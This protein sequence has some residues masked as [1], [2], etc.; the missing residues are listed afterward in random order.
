MQAAI[1]AD[2]EELE[3]SESDVLESRKKVR[4]YLRE[5]VLKSRPEPQLRNRSVLDQFADEDAKSSED[6]MDYQRKLNTKGIENTDSDEESLDNRIIDRRSKGSRNAANFQIEDDSESFPAVGFEKVNPCIQSSGDRVS[7]TDEAFRRDE[8]STYES[9]DEDTNS[10]YSPMKPLD[11]LAN[12]ETRSL[13]PVWES[14]KLNGPSVETV[15]P[16]GSQTNNGHRPPNLLDTEMQ[17]QMESEYNPDVDSVAPFTSESDASDVELVDGFIVDDVGQ[18]QARKK[19]RLEG[20]PRKRSIQQKIAVP[21]QSSSG[22]HTRRKVSER[23]SQSRLSLSKPRNKRQSRLTHFQTGANLS[24]SAQAYRQTAHRHRFTVNNGACRGSDL[25]NENGPNN[26][27]FDQSF[28]QAA[29]QIGTEER[30]DIRNSQVSSNLAARGSIRVRVR[31]ENELLL[32]PCI[33][34][35]ERKTIKWL[36]DQVFMLFVYGHLKF[37]EHYKCL[38]HYCY[39]EI[40][41]YHDAILSLSILRRTITR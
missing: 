27:D 35:S 34:S 39:Y 17:A 32:I 9:M 38:Q 15:N 28:N 3:G 7:A 25:A 10:I 4:A 18:S 11:A 23:G 24:Q 16:I 37:H 1:K 8:D 2:E 36:A 29:R 21:G 5:V 40:H 20:F 30:D 33:D 41:H 6:E 22:V 19:R 12:N 14:A 31:V 26:Q 13:G